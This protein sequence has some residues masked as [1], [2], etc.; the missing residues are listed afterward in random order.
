GAATWCQPRSLVRTPAHWRFTA[1]VLSASNSRTGGTRFSSIRSSDLPWAAFCTNKE[2]TTTQHGS[3]FR[4]VVMI[5]ACILI[6]VVTLVHGYK[7]GGGQK[8]MSG[9]K[10]ITQ[11]IDVRLAAMM[12]S[13][14]GSE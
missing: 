9:Q 11:S 8:R 3:Y 4:P 14:V 2:R 12:I 7:Q 10:G 6:G 13:V 5:A 1:F